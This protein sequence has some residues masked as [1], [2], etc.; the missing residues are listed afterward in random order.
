M[1][2]IYRL[3]AFLVFT[4]LGLMPDYFIYGWSRNSSSVPT[5]YFT[6]GGI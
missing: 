6:Y 2:A 4:H 3:L 5:I 1:P